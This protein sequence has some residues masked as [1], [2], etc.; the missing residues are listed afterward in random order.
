MQPDFSTLQPVGG[1]PTNLTPSNSAQPDFSTLQPVAQTTQQPASQNILQ[2]AG[3]A[4]IGAPVTLAVR[5]GQLMGTGVAKIAS[6]VT[7]NEDYYNNAIKSLNQPSQVPVLG[8]NIPPINQETPESIAGEGVS[9]VGLGVGNPAAAGVELGAGQAMQENKSPGEVATSAAV[10]GAVG[11][12]AGAA[13][14]GFG[15]LLGAAG[16]KIMQTTIKP[17]KADIEDGFSMGTIQKYNLGGSLSTIYDKTE[18]KLGQLT[19]QLHSKLALSDSSIDLNKVV[20]D[21]MSS[22]QGNKLK[23][24]GSNTSIEGAV[25]QLKDEVSS[26]PGT[27]QLSIPDAQLVKQAAGRM[28]AWQYGVSDPSSTARQTVYNKFYSTLKTAIEQG[29]PDGVK[30][31]NKQIS[32]LIPIANAVIRRIPVAERNSALSLTDMITLTASLLDP[33]ALVGFGMSMAQKSGAV[34]NA[35]TKIAPAISGASSVI[36]KGAAI[37]ASN[38][39]Q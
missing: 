6:L 21:T 36:G 2:K 12:I 33:R 19:Q 8:T 5:A 39:N 7:G 26:L 20:Q 9:T 22:L 27:G 32:E 38:V 4:V 37:G 13:T 18:T 3:Q 17:L 35:L 15:K 10:G 29:S 11:G 24:F 16:E 25:N 31:V 30:E 34:G 1:A 23:S 28:G 14:Y